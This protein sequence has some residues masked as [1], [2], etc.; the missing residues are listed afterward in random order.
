[1]KFRLG[2]VGRGV[3]HVG[4][5]ER[6]LVQWPDR[7]ALVHVDVLDAEF[8]ALLQVPVGARVGELP[9]AGA[10][11]PLGG[12]QLAALGAEP[13]HVAPEHLEPLVPVPRI[14]AGVVDELARVLLAHQRVALGG[15]EALLVPLLQIGRLEHG[16]VHIAVLEDVLHQVFL[17]VLLEVLQRPVRLRRAQ[18]HVGV[19]AFDPALGVLLRPGHP[20]VRGGVPVVHVAVYHE[21]LLA[22]LLVH[23]VSSLPGV[24][25]GCRAA[26]EVRYADVGVRSKPRYSAASSGLANMIVRSSRWIIRP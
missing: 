19:E 24:S 9:A 3:V 21:V 23:R 7:R 8:L 11:V 25:A 26:V 14:P 5:V 17:G 1:M 4:H 15:V 13:L 6:V 16:H 20:V 12:V 10:V 18:A 22:V 2:E